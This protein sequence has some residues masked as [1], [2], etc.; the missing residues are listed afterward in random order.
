[1]SV[2]ES[3]LEE[4]QRRSLDMIAALEDE[5]KAYPKGSLA[6][7]RIGNKDYCYLRYREGEKVRL[8]YIGSAELHADELGAAIEKR[9]ACQASIKQAKADLKLLG[10]ALKE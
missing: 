7:K 5:L 10:R 9:R 1:M 4:E 8:K 6:I 3:M 2:L